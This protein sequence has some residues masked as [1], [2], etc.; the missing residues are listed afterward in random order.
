ML[1]RVSHGPEKERPN[2]LGMCLSLPFRV[3]SSPI[4]DQDI[5]YGIPEARD[6]TSTA[7]F[8]ASFSAERRAFYKYDVITSFPGMEAW[9]LAG[10][11]WHPVCAPQNK[12]QDSPNSPFRISTLSR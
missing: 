3:P 5:S 12:L 9:C 11:H 2:L 8:P 7:P 4:R 10:W 6:T 1:C